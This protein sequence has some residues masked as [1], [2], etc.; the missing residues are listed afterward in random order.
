MAQ[1]ERE[2]ASKNIN[3]FPDEVEN[4]APEVKAEAS[5]RNYEKEKTRLGALQPAN[6]RKQLAKYR[7]RWKGEREQ[8]AE[9]GFRAVAKEG[10]GL[11]IVD[12]FSDDESSIESS[13]TLASRSLPTDSLPSSITAEN[14]NTSTLDL[15]REPAA[16]L[17]IDEQTMEAELS[18][19]SDF[20]M[21]VEL[22]AAW[23]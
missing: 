10:P 7:E 23:L 20:L 14:K 22:D 18:E 5:Y 9:E 6:K 17:S 19:M 2:C 15:E 11:T 4:K 12:D 8:E 3:S 13:Q 16:F 1:R 21:A